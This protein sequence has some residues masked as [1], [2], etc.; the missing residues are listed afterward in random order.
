MLCLA[1]TCCS[2]A[3]VACMGSSSRGLK[4]TTV[5]FDGHKIKAEVAVTPEQREQGLGGRGS[6]PD[7]RG[8]L[9]DMQQTA[10]VSFWMKGMRFA[11]DMVWIGT[12]QRVV[13]VTADV[14][15]QPGAP[16]SALRIY[17]PP[18]PVRYVFELNAGAAQRLGLAEGTQLS[19]TL[20]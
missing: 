17:M 4:T 16:D 6:L 10:V 8:M 13:G 5:S 14:P 11:L 19:F 3:F 15:P 1:L 9:F 2:A 20:P 18:S 12:D 7:D